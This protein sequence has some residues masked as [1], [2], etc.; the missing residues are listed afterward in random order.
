M[1][2]WLAKHTNLEAVEGVGHRVVHG[3]PHYSRAQ[4]ITPE[5]IDD[6]K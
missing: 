2:P 1:K 5:L 3:G 4:R 6:L